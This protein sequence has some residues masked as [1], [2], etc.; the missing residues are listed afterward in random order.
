MT[1][2]LVTSLLFIISGCDPKAL[3]PEADA[4]ASGHTSPS[5]FT[6]EANQAILADVASFDPTDFE[7]ARKGLIASDPQLQVKG[8]LG[9]IIFDQTAFNFIKGDAPASVNP[10]LWRQEKLNNIHGLFK[11]S[12]GIYQLRGHDLSNMTLIEGD[13]G[14]IIV[15]PLSSEETAQ[16][17]LALARKELGDKA[18]SGIIFTHSHVD[19]FGGVLGIISAEQVAANAIPI[20]APQGFMAEATSENVIAGVTMGRRTGFAYGKWLARDERGHIGLGLGKTTPMGSMGILPPTIIIDRTPQ[21][22]QIDGV[23][24]IFQ[25]VPGSEAPAELTFYLPKHKAFCGAEL[26]SRNMHNIYTL[27]GAKVRDALAW[28][29]YI[30]QAL[31]LFGDA[32]IYFASH[33]WP[34]WGNEAV[35]TFLKQQRDTYKYIHDQTLRLASQ[36]ATPG[37][38]A[39]QIKLPQSLSSVSSSRGYYGTLRHNARAVYQHYFGWFDANPAHL[40]PLP[41]VAASTRYVSAMGGIEQVITLA[42]QAYDEGDYRWTAELLNHAVFAEPDHKP[43]RALLARCYDQM[44]YQAE[45]GPWRDIYLSAALELRQGGTSETNLNL[46]NAKHL[47]QQTPFENLFDALATRLNGPKA[48]GVNLTLNINFTDIDSNYVL[49]IENAVLHHKK[50]A[51][52]PEANTTL[53]IDSTLYTSIILGEADIKQLLNSDKLSLEGS[54]LDLIKFFSLLESPN[55]AFNIIEP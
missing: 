53:K 27:R 20:I 35:T 26:V 24:F 51:P 22:M 17:A 25:N 12:E 18:I 45:S 2:M 15:D 16:R 42:Q 3:P 54:T 41:P 43:A 8:P 48:D 6:A 38:I 30:H 1:T 32:D 50:A 7:Q 11:V 28:S 5:T 13:T 10:S 33:H 39:E 36:G 9:H 46:S 40:N 47:L 4:N 52:D 31:E 23:D 49:W 55:M 29:N 19:H 14:W 34:I 21:A 37:E 44:G